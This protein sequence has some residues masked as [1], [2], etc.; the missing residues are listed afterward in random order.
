MKILLLS[1]FLPFFFL[2]Y[3]SVRTST[4][5]VIRSEVIG[6]SPSPIGTPISPDAT[7]RYAPVFP[8]WGHYHYSV[9]TL[10]D[11][12]QYYFDQ[13]LS[14]YYSYHLKESLASFKEAALKDSTCAM[15]YWGQ[16]LAMGPFY[17]NSYD[18]KMPS[19][20]LPV[21]DRMNQ[22]AEKASERERDLIAALNKK[23]SP[24][25]TDSR[26]SDLNR[27]Y[28]ENMKN[29]IAKYPQDLDIK[30][31]YIDGVM[32]EHAWDMWDPKG[33]PMPWTPGLVDLCQTILAVNPEHPGALHYHIHLLEASGHPE[34]TLSSADKL[35]DL[36]PGVAHMVHMASHSYQRTGLYGKGV[37][38]ND[39]ANA[40]QKNYNLMA[41]QLQLTRL[42]IHYYAVEAYCALSG[43]LYEK[44][45][46]PA[47]QCAKIAEANPS[48]RT[49]LY[50]QY[51][52]MIPAFVQ[53]RMGKWEALLARPVPDTHWVFASLLSDFARGI[54]FV[55][56]GKIDSAQLC[57]DR[58]KGRMKDP[59]LE[60]RRRPFNAP[61]D[62]AK[63]AEGIL[64]GEVLFARR[65]GDVPIAA[66]E[67]AIAAEDGLFY[68]EP[69]DWLL[70]ARHFA[71]VCLLKQQRA[72]EAEKLYREDL[73]HN[74]GNGWALMGLS[75]SLEL[76]HKKGAQEYKAR[77]RAAFTGAEELPSGSAY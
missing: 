72:G 75:Q 60:D 42:V 4:S 21:L 15:I 25:T 8:G 64:E 65:G 74:P 10:V 35:K 62:V 37:M 9:S 59:T 40:A 48:I 51:L 66:F 70:P 77:A 63:V 24:D 68:A 46:G 69:K 41:P 29:L 47:V 57:L 50:M 39:S 13:G 55:R 54:A 43:G 56:T 26:R 27:D 34:A 36:M 61:V 12:A 44:A 14:L 2:L 17:N 38:V 11:S 5:Q 20:V 53:V 45:M 22:L 7:G 52:Y 18:Y 73:E 23:Y 28:S 6:C 76:Q 31:L 32:V 1:C 19:Q 16:A 67:R 58:L 30:A 3:L 49:G 71:G 33:Q